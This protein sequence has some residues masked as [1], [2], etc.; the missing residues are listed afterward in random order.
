MGGQGDVDDHMVNSGRP[1]RDIWPH[2][3]LEVTSL[4]DL[5]AVKDTCTVPAIVFRISG[6]EVVGKKTTKLRCSLETRSGDRIVDG[7]GDGYQSFWKDG[8]SHLIFVS[9]NKV[10]RR[11]CSTSCIPLLLIGHGHCSSRQTVAGVTRWSFYPFWQLSRFG[12]DNLT[13][14]I[15]SQGGRSQPRP[16]SL[17]PGRPMTHLVIVFCITYDTDARSGPTICKM[18][19]LQHPLPT[20]FEFIECSAST[21]AFQMTVKRQNDCPFRRLAF[22]Y[23]V[24]QGDSAGNQ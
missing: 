11:N 13:L 17:G 19:E 1:H 21:N 16:T 8:K 22:V 10:N 18:D 5:E 7:S 6:R 23:D 9:F 3:T 2:D 15:D 4:D 12:R 14:N 24:V 20:A